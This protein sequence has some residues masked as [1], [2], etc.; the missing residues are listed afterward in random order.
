MGDGWALTEPAWVG[1]GEGIVAPGT[2]LSAISVSRAAEQA[3][4]DPVL[5]TLWVPYSGGCRPRPLPYLTKAPL[6]CWE[7]VPGLQNWKHRPWDVEGR[8]VLSPSPFCP[9]LEAVTTLAWLYS[10]LGFLVTL[11]A[12]PSH[13]S[14]LTHSGPIGT[15]LHPHTLR[16][17]AAGTISKSSLLVSQVG[18]ICPKP[19]SSGNDCVGE[20]P[21]PDHPFSCLAPAR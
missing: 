11:W 12:S 16:C 17:W 8:M 20:E 6:R 21:L 9:S 18:N 13:L 7:R 1:V 5:P 3:P 14:T 2:F 19:E 10:S 4:E 15:T